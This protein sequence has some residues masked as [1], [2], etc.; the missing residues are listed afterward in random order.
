MQLLLWSHIIVVLRRKDDDVAWQE[1][2]RDHAL[3]E[4]GYTPENQKWVNTN[5]RCMV[6]IKNT[7]ENA[8]AGS[9][10]KCASAWEFLEKI[11]SQFTGSS[12]D[13]CPSC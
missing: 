11:K 6:F 10:A 12:K 2:K 5:K 7:I 1:K 4:M 8:I 13:I 9:I 3:L